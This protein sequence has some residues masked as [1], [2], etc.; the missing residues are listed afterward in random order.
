MKRLPIFFLL[1][2]AAVAVLLA[3]CVKM[4]KPGRTNPDDPDDPD[5][6]I[7]PPLRDTFIRMGMNPG[8]SR[9]S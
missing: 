7:S 9:P 3:G 5:D 2:A 6:P 4:P 1:F 8:M